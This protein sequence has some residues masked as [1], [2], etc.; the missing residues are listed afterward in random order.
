MALVP[1]R[2]CNTQVS[3]DAP[4]CPQC[5]TP[6]PSEAKWHGSGYEWKSERTILGIPLVHVAFGKDAKGKL[7][8]AKGIVAIG[9]FGI[10]LITVAQFGI[11][12][13][14]GFGQ[15]LLGLTA[16]AQFAGA[17][18]VSVGQFSTGIVT[19]G[20][21]SFGVYALC[22]AGYAKY[23]WSAQHVDM[24]AVALFSTIYLKLTQLFGILP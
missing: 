21:V 23:L 2:E 17:L 6:R 22:Q 1:C 7:R 20:Q 10:G 13:L 3:T 11:G 12:V 16:V 18:L 8:V 14:F 5:G 9:Q 19:I 15:F 4:M 24:E